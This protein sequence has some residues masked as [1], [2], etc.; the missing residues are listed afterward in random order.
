MSPDDPED[1]HAANLAPQ[2]STFPTK[3][4]YTLLAVCDLDSSLWRRCLVRFS[5]IRSWSGSRGRRILR[6][7]R[8]VFEVIRGGGGDDGG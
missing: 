4:R 3:A 2:M 5:M 1:S 8:L 6:R 7:L